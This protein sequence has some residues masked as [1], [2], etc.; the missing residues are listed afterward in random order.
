MFDRLVE[1][2]KNKQ[3]SRSGSF[4]LL[5]GLIYA[6]LLTVLAVWTIIGFSPGLAEG[7]DWVRLTPPVPYTAP[8]PVIQRTVQT[9]NRVAVDSFVTPTGENK[10]P[11]PEELPQLQ[12]ISGVRFPGLP[13]G[14][15][16]Q[17]T[18]L[19]PS[20][21]SPIGSGGSVPVP[22]P[23]A[24]KP[25]PSPEPAPTPKQ[26]VQ[27]S[28]GVIQGAAIIKPAPA[29]PSIAKQAGVQGAVQIL[30]TISEEGR[31]IDASIVSGHPLLRQ[32]TL[33]AARRWI[34]NPTTLTE[35]PVKVQGILT[36]NFTLY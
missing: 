22:P 20:D 31:V 34:F 9:V 17:D 3:R 1:S 21:Y 12:R 36:F 19:P 13:N 15:G 18:G 27:V 29:Y 23:P 8:Q 7:V 25:K 33:D 4:L 16:G 30:V 10:I 24:P 32:A 11:P 35:V 5:T 14:P 28:K 26:T 6:M 2:T